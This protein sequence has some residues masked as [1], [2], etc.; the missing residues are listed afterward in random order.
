MPDVARGLRLMKLEKDKEIVA[1]NEA[2]RRVKWMKEVH[3][4]IR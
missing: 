2:C 3:V 1:S 4:E